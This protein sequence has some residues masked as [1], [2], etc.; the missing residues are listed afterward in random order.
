[1]DETGID[2]DIH[3]EFAWSARGRA[4]EGRVAGRRFERLGLVACQRQGE[5]LAPLQ[6]PG[7]MDSELF[8]SWFAGMLPPRLGVGHLV[9]M[10][11]ASFHRK[12]RLRELAA[13]QGCEVLFL[14][15]YSPD[16][17]PIEKFWAWLKK[18]LRK[19]MRAFVSLSE[20]IISCFKKKT[21]LERISIK[22]I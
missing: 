9:V 18:R 7:T 22:T 3:R 21:R 1:V 8:E 13:V 4:V 14:P 5:I 17:N 19:V 16:F 20:A 11:Y 6:Y 12:A 15:P 2:A 10:D